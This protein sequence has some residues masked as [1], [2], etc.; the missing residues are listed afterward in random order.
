MEITTEQVKALR[1]EAAQHGDLAQAEICDAALND[2]ATAWAI[3]ENVIA[4]AAAMG[5]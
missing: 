1:D 3:C 5:E 2:D 4:D